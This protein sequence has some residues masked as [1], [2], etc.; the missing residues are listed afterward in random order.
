M[1]ANLKTC[2]GEDLY[3]HKQLSGTKIPIGGK[4]L[5]VKHVDIARLSHLLHIR[6]SSKRIWMRVTD[7]ADNRR[8]ICG[9]S[10]TFL[11]FLLQCYSGARLLSCLVPYGVRTFCN[12]WSSLQR[13]WPRAIA[14][15][16]EV[17]CAFLTVQ[18]SGSHFPPGA[19][20][21]FV[22]QIMPLKLSPAGRRFDADGTGCTFGNLC[23]E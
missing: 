20:S 10:K 1:W 21:D 3:F 22:Y 7:P 13:P 12:L 9:R 14:S 17:F 23:A 2:L 6:L 5:S 4:L 16:S 11:H 15:G 18:Q 8:K 19:T